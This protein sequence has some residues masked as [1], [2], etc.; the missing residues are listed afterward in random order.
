ME[1]GG[2]SEGTRTRAAPPRKTQPNSAEGTLVS[3]PCPPRPAQVRAPSAPFPNEHLA[4]QRGQSTR[5]FFP[6]RPVP[7][8]SFPVP[9][10]SPSLRFR[11]TLSPSHSN[12][13]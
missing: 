10:P 3:A 8:L 5:P 9:N 11:S 13:L 7:R 2:W 4:S 12:Y 1:A 6:L